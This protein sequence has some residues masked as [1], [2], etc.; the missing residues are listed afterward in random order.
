MKDAEKRLITLRFA[1]T[2]EERFAGTV[3]KAAGITPKPKEG[4]S[5]R[6]AGAKFQAGKPFLRISLFS[7]KFPKRILA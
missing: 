7:Q 2:V 6:I 5:A 4:L 3:L 1:T